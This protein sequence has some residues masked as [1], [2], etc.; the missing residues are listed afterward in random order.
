MGDV[1]RQVNV[2]A[3]DEAMRRLGS[4]KLGRIVFTERALPA[5]RLASHVVDDGGIIVRSGEGAVIVNPSDPGG[6]VVAYEAD[7]I[8][9]RSHLG[10]TVTVTGVA[11]L[12]DDPHL[13]ARYQ[14]LVR[15]RA[16]G[17]RDCTI[18]IDADLVTGFELAAEPSELSGHS[19]V[20]S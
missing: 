20:G 13:L 9:P 19:H 12:V 18:R 8:D 7:A 5:V 10:W 14:K 1:P 6:T 11:R 4:V 15:P 16:A 2:L 3:R 17:N